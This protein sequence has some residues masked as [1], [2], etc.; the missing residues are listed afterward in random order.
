[1]P[2]LR[3]PFGRLVA[4]D[5]PVQYQEYLKNPGFTKP[6][7][8]EEKEHILERMTRVEAMNNSQQAKGVYFSTV[9]QGNKDGYSIASGEIINALNALKVQ[10]T[11]FYNGQKIAMLMHNPYSILR[12]EAPYRIV[13]TMFESDKIPDDWYDYL[14]AA[15]KILVPSKWCQGVFAKANIE[16]E[17]LP[18]GYNDNVFTY[19]ERKNKVKNR[20]DFVFLHYN[21][22]NIRKGFPEVFKAFNK[23][24]RKDEPVKLIL[25][26]HLHQIPLPITKKEYPNIEIVNEEF[27]PQQMSEIVYR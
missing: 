21:A 15:D 8:Q 12:I 1:M 9:S 22:F 23:A 26:T 25:K 3:N 5:D 18:L 14:K 13:Y 10:T 17:V 27:N 2:Y 19:F 11:T 7:P 16:T 20:Q 6:T 24:F 4:V